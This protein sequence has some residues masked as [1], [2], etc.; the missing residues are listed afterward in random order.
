MFFFF[1]ALVLCLSLPNKR[2][3]R[4]GSFLQ[5]FST[6]LP[7]VHVDGVVVEDGVKSGEESYAGVQ[8]PDPWR[9]L[10]SDALA[11]VFPIPFSCFNKLP[12]EPGELDPWHRV[13]V[14]QRSKSTT[15]LAWS[16]TNLAVGRPR[17]VLARSLLQQIRWR[18]RFI[19]LL[20]MTR[21]YGRQ[22]FVA[23]ATSTPPAIYVLVR[24]QQLCGSLVSG[25]GVAAGGGEVEAVRSP[26][27]DA[28]VATCLFPLWE[29]CHVRPWDGDKASKPLD[30]IR[31]RCRIIF[32]IK[33]PLCRSKGLVCNFISLFSPCSCCDVIP[34]QI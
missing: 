34:G 24:G 16:L 12:G 20:A 4:S 32:L 25:D 29:R 3:P 11:P 28:W 14:W 1:V 10:S 8:L 21:P 26:S 23:D 15:S 19:F 2:V 17:Y 9:G 6:P 7:Q 18:R 31:T 13:L 30:A 27:T 33:G 5:F 22:D